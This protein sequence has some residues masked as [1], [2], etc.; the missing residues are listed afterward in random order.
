MTKANG[1][2]M[3]ARPVRQELIFSTNVGICISLT[4]CVSPEIIP[5]QT[6]CSK[7]S[8]GEKLI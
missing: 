4:Y 5:R 7:A 1:W 2:A 3:L 6:I 8:F